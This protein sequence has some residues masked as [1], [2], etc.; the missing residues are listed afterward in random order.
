MSTATV[1]TP[2]TTGTG[3]TVAMRAM[4]DERRRV[5]R[6]QFGF[7]TFRDP[8]T[9]AITMVA[10]PVSAVIT[11][12]GL[13]P[14]VRALSGSGVAPVF[15]VGHRLWVFLADCPTP[16]DNTAQLTAGLFEYGA[17]PLVP[18]TLIVLPT[19]GN[20]KRCWMYLPYGVTRPSFAAMV[21]AF[22]TAATEAGS[23]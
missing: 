22:Q 2:L 21:E 17:V 4:I 16:T 3:T 19:P 9:D 7:N 11:P 20:E 12:R 13:G 14:R 1:S 23:L 10:G 15:S 18:G 6:D 5:Y 8:R